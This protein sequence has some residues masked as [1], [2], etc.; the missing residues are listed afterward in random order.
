MTEDTSRAWLTSFN[1]TS[2]QLLGLNG[3][4]FGYLFQYKP[5]T[6]KERFV[7]VFGKYFEFNIKVNAQNNEPQFIIDSVKLITSSEAPSVNTHK[8]KE[9]TSGKTPRLKRPAAL[10]KTT[11]SKVSKS[12]R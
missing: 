12:Q 7:D 11:T 9:T 2:L 1:A 5:D 4:E 3:D 10:T 6:L 8:N